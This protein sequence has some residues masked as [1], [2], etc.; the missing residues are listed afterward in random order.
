MPKRSG[1]GQRG[2]DL[3]ISG[4]PG[5]S[6]KQKSEEKKPSGKRAASNSS[7]RSKSASASKSTKTKT[8][9]KTVT[10]KTTGS[11]KT[12]TASKKKTTAKAIKKDVDAKINASILEEQL[13]EET[14]SANIQEEHTFPD[15]LKQEAGSSEILSAKE[16]ET[17]SS[18]KISEEKT[19]MD[20][21]EKA[22]VKEAADE[23]TG[24][25]TGESTD[26]STDEL[27]GEST[28]DSVDEAAS[29]AVNESAGDAEAVD[30]G[31]GQAVD[32]SLDEVVNNEPL[33]V[34]I[35]KVEPNRTQPRKNFDEDALQ[36]LAD[37]IRQFGVIQPL[38]VQKRD[39]YYEIIAGERRW[40]AARLASL[41][42]VPV[43]VKDYT[44]REV[45]EISL[46]ENIQ[47]EDL[48]PI[49][50]AAAYRRLMDEYELKQDEVAERVSKS[51][52]SIANSVRLL[53]LDP[54]VQEMV[55]GEML[56]TGHARALLA[57]TDPEVQYSTAQKVFD[58]KLTVRDVE[59]LVKKM[60]QAPVSP[61]RKQISD[62]L[63]A[64]YMDL[65]EKM[66]VSL[67][68]KVSITPRSAQKGKIEIEYYSQDELDRLCSLLNGIG[69]REEV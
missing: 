18:E 46:I 13:Y 66:K 50:E 54:R 33:M 69:Q 17:D 9:T 43:L 59:K 24:E 26:D 63:Q 38:I 40:R 2:L 68:T 4:S 58:E 15:T 35:S 16:L 44:P 32:G 19:G 67:G 25:S 1:L 23:S 61:V 48:N 36:E 37:S 65:S 12:E 28:D 56:S 45:M 14:V 31:P 29:E 8:A 5:A 49:E 7:G 51:R 39:D 64:I 55:I 20:S 6:S 21:S 57:I 34:P 47:R 11:K 53:N 27:T 42:E 41:K 52:T 30:D 62:A 3:L 60:S 22:S 10:K